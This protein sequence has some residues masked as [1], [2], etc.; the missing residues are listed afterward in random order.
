MLREVLR[1]H[2][3]S[4]PLQFVHHK[5]LTEKCIK[6]L[7]STQEKYLVLLPRVCRSH[8]LQ[9]I[10]CIIGADNY[11]EIVTDIDLTHFKVRLQPINN[12]C[13]FK[14]VLKRQHQFWQQD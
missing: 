6:Q 5:T 8:V 13:E 12:V 1:Q 14:T 7:L 11:K 9:L 4:K 3:V 2:L 10:Y